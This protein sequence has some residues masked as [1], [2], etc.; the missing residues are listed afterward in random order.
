M[1]LRP[2][3]SIHELVCG[4]TSHLRAGKPLA[5]LKAYADD[6][7]SDLGDRRLF[8]AGYLNSTWQWSLFAD[9]WH[10]ELMEPP[11]VQY[12]HMVEANALRGQFAGWGKEARDQKLQSLLRVI[13]Q[14]EPISFEFSINRV[15]VEQLLAPNAPRGLA[16][17]HFAGIL[18][19]V[20]GIAE[21]MARDGYKGKIDFI[22]DTQDGVSTDIALFWDELMKSF[23]RSARNAI[24]G[25]P[26]FRDDKDLMPLQAADM[27]SWH[28]RK[29]HELGGD[30][31]Q[32]AENLRH[33]EWHFMSTMPA[34]IL[35]SLGEQISA[36]PGVDRVKS[37]GD[38][39]KVKMSIVEARAK[40]FRPPYGTRWRNALMGI[41]LWL[42]RV[43]TRPRR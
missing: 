32:M 28:L 16:S 6:S 8:I 26:I 29:E 14:F 22:F 20:I 15:E 39:R 43:T 27:L 33:P 1:S 41:L 35:Q 3:D 34:E 4:Y 23:P 21:F 12:L 37:K 5:F 7:G 2:S 38:W 18:R 9:A 42:R 30:A 24:S 19:I 17:P 11:S 31:L 25:P 13:R 10:E 36:V 40:G